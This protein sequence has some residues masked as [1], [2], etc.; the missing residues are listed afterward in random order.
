MQSEPLIHDAIRWKDLELINLKQSLALFGLTEREKRKR[1]DPSSMGRTNRVESLPTHWW[2]SI[3]V[4]GSL[5]G[6]LYFVPKLCLLLFEGLLMNLVSVTHRGLLFS[7]SFSFHQKIPSRNG[8]Q[9]RGS[10]ESISRTI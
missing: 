8:R 5:P 9:T 2:C 7:D 3:M 6:S 4:N 10:H 1:P